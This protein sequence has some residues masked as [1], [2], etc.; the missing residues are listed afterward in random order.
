MTKRLVATNGEQITIDAG[1]S[2][3]LIHGNEKTTQMVYVAAQ[4]SRMLLSHA[5]CEG[6]GHAIKDFPMIA[7]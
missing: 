4:A 6:L 1:I 7:A 3:Y 2:L 5:A